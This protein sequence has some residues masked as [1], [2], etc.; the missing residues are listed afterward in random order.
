MF[1]KICGITDPDTARFAVQ[2]GADA[3]GVVMSE[4]SPRHVNRETAADVVAAATG[5]GIDTVLVVREMPASVAAR[6]AAE[7]GFDALQLHG[8]YSPADFAAAAADFPRIW[9]ATSLAEEPDVVAGELGEE[10]LLLD[11]AQAGSGRPWDLSSIDPA[12]LGDRWLLAGGLNPGTVAEAIARARPWGVDVSSGVES[13]PGLKDVGL[14][15]RFI[16]AARPSA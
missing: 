5:P 8:S 2:Q 15:S 9:R 4:P 11:G 1:I 10:R 3:I 13:A 14:I 7:L 12:L 16:A 6:T